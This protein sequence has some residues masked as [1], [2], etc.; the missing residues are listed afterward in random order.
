[1]HACLSVQLWS[2]GCNLRLVKALAQG[3][4]ILYNHVVKEVK[5]EQAG[6]SVTAGNTVIK[7]DASMQA[8]F[9][10]VT[11]CCCSTRRPAYAFG[12][13]LQDV[14]TVAVFLIAFC[15]SVL[16]DTVSF[17]FAIVHE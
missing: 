10:P 12:F 4:P 8:V 1:M 2:A 7:G 17:D 11:A 13:S 6:V 3:L 16:L 5:Y 15:W 14:K 9:H